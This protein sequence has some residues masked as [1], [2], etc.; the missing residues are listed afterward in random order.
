MATAT[1][2]W[3]LRILKRRLSD[4]V[5]Q[6]LGADL[7]V[8]R[9]GPSVGATVTATD[10]ASRLALGRIARKGECAVDLRRV[11]EGA[12]KDGQAVY[13]SYGCVAFDPGAD[14]VDDWSDGVSSVALSFITR[15]QTIRN[16]SQVIRSQRGGHVL[17]E[18][19]EL[20]GLRHLGYLTGPISAAHDMS[21]GDL[22]T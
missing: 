12:G 7:T 22:A 21:T 2:D 18:R 13:G 14:A 4:V 16:Q 5:Y 10:F 6:A 11:M 1:A 15:G 8:H 17:S 19:S 3:K 9:P 20:I